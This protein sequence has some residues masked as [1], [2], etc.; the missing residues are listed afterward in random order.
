MSPS[1]LVR[2]LGDDAA[3]RAN[4]LVVPGGTSPIVVILAYERLAE[5]F[6]EAEIL[7]TRPLC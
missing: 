1:V 6:R 4:L 2:S 7:E 5:L 3:S